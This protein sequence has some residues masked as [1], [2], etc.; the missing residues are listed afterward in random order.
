MQLLSA[1]GAAVF[2]SN[3]A[4]CHAVGGGRTPPLA[5]LQDMTPAA[6]HRAL[7]EGVMRQQGARLDE[8]QRIAVSEFV[9]N[10]VYTAPGV[11]QPANMCAGK[12]AKFDYASPPV[13]PGPA[14]RNSWFWANMST[15]FPIAL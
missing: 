3:C 2:Q 6:V 7:T 1:A 8:A 15:M 13:F 14:G 4:M 10:R 11:A 12:A 9:A 5:L